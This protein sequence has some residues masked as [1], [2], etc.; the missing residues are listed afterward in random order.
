MHLARLERLDND[1]SSFAASRMRIG[2]EI[3]ETVNIL[4]MAPDQHIDLVSSWSTAPDFIVYLVGTH[5]YT[6]FQAQLAATA[7]EGTERNERIQM[8]LNFL[9]IRNR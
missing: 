7:F 9:R 6:C 4:S 1:E 8:V 3:M 5:E 2:L